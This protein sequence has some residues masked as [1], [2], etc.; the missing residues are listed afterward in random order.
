M[1]I[2]ARHARRFTHKRTATKAKAL[3]PAKIS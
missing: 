1:R 2:R 3:A